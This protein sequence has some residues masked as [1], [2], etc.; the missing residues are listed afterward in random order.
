MV[1]PIVPEQAFIDTKMR[2]EF[3]PDNI[4][5]IVSQ[6]NVLTVFEIDL[7]LGKDM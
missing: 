2:L 1:L 7:P 4:L 3:R 5:L 6:G